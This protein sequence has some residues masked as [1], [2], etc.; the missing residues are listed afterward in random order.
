MK[1][2]AR[3]AL[4]LMETRRASYG[5]IRLVRR[6]TE[7]IAVKKGR[8]EALSQSESRGFGVRVVVSGAWGF[9]ASSVLTAEE[10]DRVVDLAVRIARASARVK[11]R[12]VILGPPV[13]SQGE[14][15][16]PVEVDPFQVPLEDKVDLLLRADGEMRQ[17][18]GLETSTASMAFVRESKVFASTEGA[19]VEQVLIE[20]GAGLQATA[21]AEGEVQ[22]RSFPQ[23]FGVQQLKAG[24]EVVRDMGLVENAGRT[25]EEAV[26]LLQADDCPETTTTVILDS[27]QVALQLHESCGHA[28]ELDR[29]L[30]QEAGFVGT[31]FLKPE[32]RGSFR[33]GSELVSITM[34]STYPGGLGT[35][36]WDDEGVPAQQTPIVR[37]GIFHGWLMDREHAARVGLESNGASR[38][39]SW[40]HIPMVRMTNVNL[41]PG[42][43]ELENLIADTDEGL[44]LVTN[45]SWSIDDKRYNFQ[46][47]VE[48]AYEIKRGKLG[49]MIKNATYAGLT[50][51]F[52]GSCDAVCSR[53][54][55]TM[56]GIPNCGKGEPMQVAHVGHGTAPARFRGVKVGIA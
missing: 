8:L 56:W 28:I 46:F 22:Q 50:P 4:D 5:E 1:D 18:R 23:A 11:A 53:A 21:T 44:Y 31:S 38:S 27:S 16:T 20:S 42:E 24:W 47:G 17:V 30:G 51:E 25:A 12:D 29:A 15:R 32:M 41:E 43:W 34:D 10:V 52:W 49:R 33:Y 14:Y 55:W 39:D 13:R 9:A 2:L 45:K 48:L 40:S 54:H 19:L 37:D 26:A 36:G 35:Y 7:D 6:E 3:R